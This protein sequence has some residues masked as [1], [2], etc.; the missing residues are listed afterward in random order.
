MGKRGNSRK[1]KN[2]NNAWSYEEHAARLSKRVEKQKQ[3]QDQDQQQ[4]LETEQQDEVK[5]GET[6]KKRKRG[7]ERSIHLSHDSYEKK[8]ESKL[9]LHI[10]KIKREIQ[11]LRNRL[12]KWDEVEELSSY[13]KKLAEEEK[14]RK[15]L[16]DKESGNFVEAEKRGRLGPETWKLRGAARPA[17][18]VYDF[19]TRYVCPHLKAH[20]DAKNKARR[21][22]NAFH[23]C[24]GWFGRIEVEN[25]T[26]GKKNVSELLLSVCREF[27]SASMQAAL[28]NLEAKKFKSAREIFL[29]LIE[30]EGHTSLNTLTNARCRLMRMY[31][32][33][34][35]PDSARR[36]WERLP[37]DCSSV[38]IRY[39]AALLE[40]VSWNILGEDGSTK[41]AAEALLV[42]AIRSNLYCAFYIAFHETFQK[43]MEYTDEVEDAE[44]G[45]LEQAI[46]Y[47]NSEEMGSWVGTE[48]AVQWIRQVLVMA[49]NQTLKNQ[50]N[51][52]LPEEID[53]ERKL[54]NI[55]A[56]NENKSILEDNE[57]TNNDDSL[58]P[59]ILMF[60][61]MFRTAID[62]LCDAGEL[63][64]VEEES[65]DENDDIDES[66][67]E[68]SFD[69]K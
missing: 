41:Q 24:K 39:S 69:T 48:G 25:Q 20:E 5:N 58:E 57:I 23:Y 63:K 17:W 68:T 49:L 29:E 33:A 30:L 59:D 42:E 19:D 22:I 55:E 32:N 50:S 21:V 4:Q 14:K 38:W 66:S 64:F 54:S 6:S 52:L 34:N 51:G 43:V 15:E 8:E 27:L 18:E 65:F 16:E 60:A 13:R 2:N 7:Y 45:T 44:D 28:L 62:M 31:M 46:E 35:R 9:R 10:S 47:C 61:G 1:S 3:D 12:T 53:W 11:S 67:D 37:S 56:E 36:L 26:K 40:F